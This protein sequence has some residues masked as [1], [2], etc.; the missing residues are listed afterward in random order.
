MSRAVVV[1]GLIL[2][3][4]GCSPES[5]EAGSANKCALDLFPSYN[6]KDLKQC[7][8]ACIK[9]ENGTTTTCTTSCTLKGAH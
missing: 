6:S 9:C 8:P 7:V 5:N 1:I 3:L 4:A 2:T